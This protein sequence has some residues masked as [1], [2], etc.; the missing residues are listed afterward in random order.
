MSLVSLENVG[1]CFLM[2][3]F[4]LKG[5]ALGQ[6]DVGGVGEDTATVTANNGLEVSI[7]CVVK[8]TLHSEC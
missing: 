3:N 5:F 7:V 6:V 2:F 4:T 8:E 1:V